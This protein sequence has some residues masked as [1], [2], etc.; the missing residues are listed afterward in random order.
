MLNKKL[1]KQ[2]LLISS[3]LF[4]SQSDAQFVITPGT[5]NEF[6]GT[7]PII[8]GVGIGPFPNTQTTNS[9]L[10]VNTSYMLTSSNYPNIN[11]GEVFRTTCV[12]DISTFWRMERMKEENAVEYG[13]LY[14]L[15]VA[16]E[17]ELGFSPF[18]GQGVHF[19]VQA[20]YEDRV[21]GIFG[22]LRFN[23]GD[24]VTGYPP[25]IAT[26]RMRILG[27]NGFVGIGDYRTFSP[28]YLL[29]QHN[30]ADGGTFHQFT[31]AQTGIG[32]DD[33]FRTGLDANANGELNLMNNTS[34][35]HFKTNSTTQVT[36][37]GSNGNVGIHTTTPQTTLEVNG[38]IT[39]KQLIIANENQK[40]DLIAIL[41][42][43]KNEIG[44]LKEQ[45]NQ[46]TKN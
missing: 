4:A 45:I 20:S 35:M 7:D 42:E 1:F 33:G 8:R 25:G 37:L 19:Y 15:G 14:T 13:M 23:T 40:Q 2:L 31:T 17:E 27:D 6:M 34:D 36:I 18:D 39:T 32:A 12:A 22:D 11:F 41:N 46:L 30:N 44:Q 38:T 9:A 21:A 16:E 5:S 3:I 26:P 29:H 43:L 10:H 28:N 24:H